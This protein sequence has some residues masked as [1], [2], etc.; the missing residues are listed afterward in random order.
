GLLADIC[1]AQN[2][3]PFRI[4]GHDS[5]FDSVVNHLDEVAGTVRTAVQI[6]LLS[7]PVF[8]RASDLF[9][10][11]RARNVA[12]SWGQRREDWIE[13]LDHV[14][15]ASDHHAV[16]SLQTPNSSAGSD[17]YIVDLLRSEF[18]G[19]PDVVDVVRVSAVDEDVT[20]L[21]VGQKISDSFV[22]NRGRHHKPDR[23]WLRELLHQFRER[24]R[25]FRL[26]LDQFIHRCRRS[27][28]YHAVVTVFYEP[29]YHVGAHSSKTD[30]A[31]LHLYLLRYENLFKQA[32]R[33]CREQCCRAT[34]PWPRPLPHY[35]Q[36]P[37][38]PP[39]RRRLPLRPPAMPFPHPRP[40]RPPVRS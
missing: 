21:E 9:P 26:V 35:S 37:T 11:R 25:A 8:V 20:S 24:S 27:V 14:I 19:A 17:I 10:A 22:H 36:K 7:G 23:P 40:R 3:Q 34:G 31:E 5:V 30:H 33:L 39:Q 28:E 1:A 2:A 13:A 4:C 12:Y 16:T 18:L 38:T 6:T 29:P 32:L 15:L